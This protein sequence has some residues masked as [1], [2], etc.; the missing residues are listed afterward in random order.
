MKQKQ[1]PNFVSGREAEIAYAR[2]WRRIETVGAAGCL[3]PYIPRDLR[4]AAAMELDRGMQSPFV[5]PIAVIIWN[6][7]SDNYS[8]A[9]A[10]SLVLSKMA[11]S[12]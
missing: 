4:M 3:W 9:R 1:A 12:N 2:L 5:V 10:I 8:R 6:H 11:A 7:S